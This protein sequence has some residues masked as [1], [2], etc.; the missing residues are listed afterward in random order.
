MPRANDTMQ[1]YQVFAAIGGLVGLAHGYIS[2]HDTY[3][4]IWDHISRTAINAGDLDINVLPNVV[5]GAVAG[6][7]LCGLVRGAVYLHNNRGK[8]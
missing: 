1:A 2:N 8:K 3:K 7:S 6:V 5:L 4:L